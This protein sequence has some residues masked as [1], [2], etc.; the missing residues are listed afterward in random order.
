MR[1][2]SGLTTSS[3]AFIMLASWLQQQSSPFNLIIYFPTSLLPNV[4][5]HGILN[6]GKY[7]SF[8]RPERRTPLKNARP[9]CGA[10][11]PRAQ[12]LLQPQQKSQVATHA[13]EALWVEI[14]ESMIQRNITPLSLQQCLPSSTPPSAVASSS[15][16]SPVG[17]SPAHPHG[18]PPQRCSPQLQKVHEHPP[19]LYGWLR[20]SINFQRSF[21]TS[22]CISSSSVS[23]SIS[24]SSPPPPPLLHL[25]L[26][27]PR[28]SA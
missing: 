21:S 18:R 5:F 14:I 16:F 2:N 22:T 25:H 15:F 19:C 27:L 23:S 12:K 3:C 17:E 9:A 20:H 6:Y 1:S 26:H 10:L 13:F 11:L 28:T 4:K 7:S 24:S 8:T